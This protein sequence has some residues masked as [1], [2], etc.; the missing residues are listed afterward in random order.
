[1]S[2]AQSSESSTDLKLLHT[3][4]FMSDASLKS[5]TAVCEV[6]R[7]PNASEME[8]TDGKA[9]ATN[10]GSGVTAHASSLLV[11]NETTVC[12]DAE[13]LTALRPSVRPNLVCRPNDASLHQQSDSVGSDVY[14]VIECLQ[15]Q[16]LGTYSYN[17]RQSL[18][19]ERHEQ[20]QQQQPHQPVS[21]TEW[22][23]VNQTVCLNLSDKHSSTEASPTCSLAVGLTAEQQRMLAGSCLTYKGRRL[24]HIAPKPTFWSATH[25]RNVIQS[26]QQY[27]SV[28][29]TTLKVVLGQ[30]SRSAATTATTSGMT[31][32]KFDNT[33]R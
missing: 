26:P 20:Q 29:K 31:A 4:L 13:D 21:Q 23:K 14:P 18:T 12:R 10:C 27:Q 3:V 16:L 32:V 6:S 9:T 1:M 17:N 30:S 28:P 2:T 15:Q 25:F 11:H 8:V 7:C 22:H 33:E 5:E 24:C 19:S